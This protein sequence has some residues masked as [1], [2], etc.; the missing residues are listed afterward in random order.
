MRVK[1]EACKL[2]LKMNSVMPRK[3]W[4]LTCNALQP[5]VNSHGGLYIKEE[6][7]KMDDLVENPLLILALNGR[8]FRSPE[9]FSVI[10]RMLNA[11]LAASRVHFLTLVKSN[12]SVPSTPS[13]PSHSDNASTG[14]PFVTDTEKEDLCIALVSAQVSASVQILIEVCSTTADEWKISSDNFLA[15]G[16]FPN[17]LLLSSWR[18]VHCLVCCFLHQMFIADPSVAKL[19]HFQGYP[20]ELIPVLVSGVPSMHI[21]LD[22]IPE[23]LQIQNVAKQLFATQ[24]ASHLSTHYP[25][26]KSLSIARLSVNV[27]STLITVLPA[28]QHCEFFSVVLSSL[29]RFALAFPPLVRDCLGILIHLA[30]ISYCHV[31]VHD[32][33]VARYLDFGPGCERVE[34]RFDDANVRLFWDARRTFSDV[35]TDALYKFW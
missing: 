13:I 18:E 29:R 21:C 12:P 27:L 15:G 32:V 3:L 26:P 4:V 24:L 11:C 2:W 23:M 22:F 33:A 7:L 30:R 5:T 9:I 20:K 1:Q 19:V 8:V 10:L 35:V 16:K 6:V 25:L 17:N 28:H 31:S 34:A 14:S